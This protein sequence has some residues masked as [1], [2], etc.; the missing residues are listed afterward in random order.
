MQ[1]VAYSIHELLDGFGVLGSQP[2]LRLVEMMGIAWRQVRAVEG[3][4]E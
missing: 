3:G 2:G 4:C 1:Q